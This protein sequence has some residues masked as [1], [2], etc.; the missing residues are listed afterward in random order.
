MKGRLRAVQGKKGDFPT[1]R[2]IDVVAKR[3]DRNAKKGVGK[4]FREIVAE[5]RK[6]L[7]DRRW[8]INRREFANP[9]RGISWQI[10]GYSKVFGPRMYVYVWRNIL[11]VV[12]VWGENPISH[13]EIWREE[14][15]EVLLVRRIGVL[16]S[17]IFVIFWG[18]KSQKSA[19]PLLK[20]G[21][22]S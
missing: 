17:I 22:V 8:P 4:I 9:W 16:Y 21:V 18:S 19:F 3:E 5:S 1:K 14:V 13:L 15:L 12:I 11:R 10:H 20:L 6:M 7:L 2:E